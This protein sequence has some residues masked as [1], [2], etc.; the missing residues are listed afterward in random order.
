MH[1]EQEEPITQDTS[2][3]N[4]FELAA[5]N[6]QLQKEA[7]RKQEDALEQ[8]RLQAEEDEKR[9]KLNAYYGLREEAAGYRETAV[10][11]TD[12]A[13]KKMY[14]QWAIDSDR[15][16]VLLARELG[17]AIEEPVE[18]TPAEP[19]VLDKVQG[20]LKHRLGAIVQ[21]FF[22]ALV[23]IWASKNFTSIG[24]E[25]KQINAHVEPAERMNAYDITSN[26]KFFFEKYVEFW[27]IPA[28]LAKLFILAPFVALYLLPIFRSRK[29]FFTE[30]FEELTPFQRCLIAV[31]LLALLVLHSA[32]SHGVKP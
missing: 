4:E 11:E 21:V 14:V 31:S 29:D 30:F 28:S 20:L 13:S 27:D 22:L 3:M 26:Q 32:L 6:L 12:E 2:T 24:A 5:Y 10:R 15:R 25:I 9:E 18:E 1:S 19:G 8:R 23:I 17:L 7:I 16:A